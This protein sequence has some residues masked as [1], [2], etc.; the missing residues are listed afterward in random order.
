V[1]GFASTFPVV[2][3]LVDDAE[4]AVRRAALQLPPL[5]ARGWSRLYASTVVQAPEGADLDFLR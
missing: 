5:P 2:D 3:L 1:T 4:I